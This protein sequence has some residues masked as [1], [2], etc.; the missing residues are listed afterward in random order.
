MHLIS[1]DEKDSKNDTSLV[2]VP[3]MAMGVSGSTEKCLEVC[4]AK[5][6]H[7]A[8]EKFKTTSRGVALL[9]LGDLVTKVATHK[10]EDREVGPYRMIIKEC[11]SERPAMVIM[12]LHND[13]SIRPVELMHLYAAMGLQ[14]QHE[15]Q[16]MLLGRFRDLTLT[17]CLTQVAV[18][19]FSLSGYVLQNVA[20]EGSKG[21][22]AERW[23]RLALGS[24]NQ[25]S[26]DHND[27]ETKLLKNKL[28]D[29]PTAK[30]C[31]Q[32]MVTENLG[33]RHFNA[34]DNCVREALFRLQKELGIPFAFV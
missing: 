31:V 9:Q 17:V 4:I 34:K 20:D 1:Y 28:S 13:P 3:V 12:F 14:D 27:V 24:V 6:A 32:L 10:R 2:M 16:Q 26:F 15:V 23:E 25:M 5:L 30:E 29:N 22:L 21:A 33:P 8:F 19:T 7:A 18:E 11:T